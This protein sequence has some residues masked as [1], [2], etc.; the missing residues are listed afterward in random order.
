MTK[1]INRR[2]SLLRNTKGDPAEETSE[3]S[4]IY[5]QKGFI[6]PVNAVSKA[7]AKELRKDYEEAEK[8]LQGDTERL[9]LLKAYPNR[10][11]PSFDAL[12]RNKHLVRAA[13]ELLGDNILVWSAALF[14]K[15]PQSTQIVSWHQDLTYWQLNDIKEVTCWFAVSSASKKAG[16][17]KF[18]P[19]SHTNRLVPHNDTYDSNNLLS[20]GQEISVEVD[21][22]LA[23]H[24]ELDEGQASFHHGLLFH[25]SG[26]NLTNDRRIGSAIRYISASMKQNTGDRPLVTKVIGDEDFGNF[27]ILPPPKGRLLEEEFK[28]CHQDNELKKRLLL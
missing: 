8:E 18:I 7:E 4:K 16:C 13:K 10:L 6:F 21:E 26:P 11:L 17:M 1:I 19:G 15:E 9:A 3:L 14:I 23:I 22:K 20:R 24:A 27:N 25:S 12:T 28:L 2:N 5:F